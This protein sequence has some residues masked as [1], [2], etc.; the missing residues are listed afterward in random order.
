MTMKTIM[1]FYLIR[2]GG[3]HGNKKVARAN[4]ESFSNYKRYQLKLHE[5]NLYFKSESQNKSKWHPR[6][7]DKSLANLGLPIWNKL[8]SNIEAE[9]SFTKFKKY[10]KTWFGPNCWCNICAATQHF[11][12]K[13]D[14]KFL[15]WC[16]SALICFYAV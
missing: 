10:M 2:V 14:L 11:C 1:K 8:P 9:T 13:F 12:R 5:K 15:N 6:Q 16:Y 3:R 4:Y 7:G